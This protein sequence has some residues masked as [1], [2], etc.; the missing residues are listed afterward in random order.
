MNPIITEKTFY[1]QLAGSSAGAITATCIG[2]AIVGF[3]AVFCGTQLGWSSVLTIVLLA[4]LGSCGAL[5]LWFIIKAIRMKKHRVF[6][7]YGDAG[8]LAAKINK[9]MEAPVYFARGFDS[10][11][12]FATLIT[13]EFIVSGSEL[14]SYM[15][16]ND[17]TTVHT[18]E[19]GHVHTYYI[20]DPLMT[21]G[22]VAVNRIGDRYL[23]S[24]GI[25]DQTKF[26]QLIFEDRKG[27][28]H[29]YGVHHQDM[30]RVLGILQQI[31]PHIQ[32]KP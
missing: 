24:K 5:L 27:K 18:G 15:E 25:N 29:R 17:L 12:P 19:F 20:G 32:F 9:G 28:E 31:A 6:G 10:S 8:Q 2:G 30:E 3:C 13:D 11:A 22:S 26:D 14:V 21:A 16:L 1:K 23:E 7:I 4:V